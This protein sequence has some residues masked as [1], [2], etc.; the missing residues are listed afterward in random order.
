MPL[1]G[2]GTNNNR[3]LCEAFIKYQPCAR[4]F[5][6]FDSSFT[7]TH[8]LGIISS[9]FY[10]GSSGIERV[11]GH[12]EA[13]DR[14]GQALTSD[15]LTT[16]P[17]PLI[18]QRCHISAVRVYNSGGDQLLTMNMALRDYTWLTVQQR[19]QQEVGR[20]RQNV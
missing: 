15:G 12:H 18:H 16:D 3:S 9:A 11:A 8:V 19:E 4:Y 10:K 6:G 7:A 17:P 14:W 13:A 1:G 5:T 20:N 2:A